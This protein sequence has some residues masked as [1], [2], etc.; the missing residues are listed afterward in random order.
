MLG[1]EIV[2]SITLCRSVSQIVFA[3]SVLF[4]LLPRKGLFLKIQWIFVRN[5]LIEKEESLP[6]N[7]HFD[8]WTLLPFPFLLLV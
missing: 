3:R 1:F 6:L 5:G 7:E 4:C 8:V 2:S